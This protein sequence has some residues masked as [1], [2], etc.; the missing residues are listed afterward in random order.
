MG[1]IPMMPVVLAIRV[2]RVVRG[3]FGCAVCVICGSERE[4]DRPLHDA[5]ASRGRGLAKACID[6]LSRR[7]ELGVRVQCRPVDLVEHV[8][9]LP[10]ELNPLAAAHLE[11]LEDGHVRQHDLREPEERH[12]RIADIAA[13]GQPAERR[14]V[15]VASRSAWSRVAVAAG[16][17]RVAGD[18]RPD[19]AVT[20]SE[21]EVVRRR[22]RGA[23]P[24]AADPGRVPGQLP[25]VEEP[26]RQPVVP[27]SCSRWAR[28]RCS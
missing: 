1:S 8:V 21:V 27:H 28:P 4:P 5:R 13:T 25:A 11:V 18:V 16:A 12:R 14:D 3:L 20:A 7:I 15:E 10:P 19:S 2:V 17:Q 6:L 26:A 23:R 22:R 9:G 24:V